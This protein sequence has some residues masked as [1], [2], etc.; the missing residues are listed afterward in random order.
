MNRK[1]NLFGFIILTLILTS[2]AKPYYRGLYKIPP[3]TLRGRDM[4]ELYRP[5]TSVFFSGEVVVFW[6]QEGKYKGKIVTISLKNS[7]GEE[8][9]RESKRI[10]KTKAFCRKFPNL[11]PG[12]YVIEIEAKNLDNKSVKF[13]V[14]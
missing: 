12:N 4:E 6:M 10:L 1:I 5:F 7:A 8:I 9:Y 14:K 3:H 2:C 13:E 11:E